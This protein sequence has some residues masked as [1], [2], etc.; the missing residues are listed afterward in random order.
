MT[1]IT[2]SWTHA[3]QRRPKV[4]FYTDAEVGVPWPGPDADFIVDGKPKNPNIP[5]PRFVWCAFPGFDVT[6]NGNKAD[7]FVMR[8]RLIWVTKKQLLKLPYMRKDLMHRHVFF[9]LGSDG[10]PMCFRNFPD[11]PAIFFR[12]A[13]NKGMM[14]GTPTT[15][16]WPWPVDDLS[17]YP[18]EYAGGFKHGIVY[19][20]QDAPTQRHTALDVVNVVRDSPIVFD[21]HIAITPTFWG[22]MRD[23]ALKAI[24]RETFIDTL[25]ASR[26]S[27]VPGCNDYGVTRYRFYE[28]MS[29]GRVPVYIEDKRALPREDVIDYDRCCVFVKECDVPRIDVILNDWLNAHTDAE[30]LSMG[31]YGR[32]MWK[33]YLDRARW[34]Q[35]IESIVR[36]KLSI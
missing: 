3:G 32:E 21:A 35:K 12:G 27:L 9:D 4:Y 33:T 28:T 25:R 31:A 5:W 8:Q 17:D 14:K 30:I 10:D 11:I 7:I 20:G 24:L 13:A 15:V 26:L 29:L 16:A 36:K 34:G 22:N 2:G 19:Q 1:T 23:K 18:L 6:T